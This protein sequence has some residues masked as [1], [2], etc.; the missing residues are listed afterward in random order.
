MKRISFS[1]RFVNEMGDDLVSGKIHT[2]RQNYFY[3]KKFEG[4]HAALFTWEGKLYRSKQK[5]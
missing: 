2:I 1:P 5:G 3:W 4:R